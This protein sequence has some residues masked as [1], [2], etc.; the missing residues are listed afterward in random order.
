MGGALGECFV[1]TL[2]LLRDVLV[3]I[4]YLAE[5][6]RQVATQ[7]EQLRHCL[8]VVLSFQ[9]VDKAEPVLHEGEACWVVV[10]PFEGIVCFGGNIV[11]FYAHALQPFCQ[12]ARQ[13]QM[14]G[15]SLQTGYGCPQLLRYIRLLAVEQAL[16]LKERLLYLLGVRQGVL[17][18]FERILLV[19][20]E[21]CLGELR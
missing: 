18:L 14:L 16:R 8:H 17:F 7:G 4:L 12:V 3:N 11:E 9:F 15:H 1:H 21:L 10:R 20:L 5:L 6:L 13:G 19:L 2:L